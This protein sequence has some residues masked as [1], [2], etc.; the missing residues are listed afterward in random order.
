MALSLSPSNN[1]ILRLYQCF[2]QPGVVAEDNPGFLGVENLR[3]EQFGSDKAQE[4]IQFLHQH[5]SSA[6]QACR[7]TLGGQPVVNFAADS[8]LAWFEWPIIDELA[9]QGQMSAA[10]YGILAELRSLLEQYEVDHFWVGDTDPLTDC[11]AVLDKLAV[12]DSDEQPLALEISLDKATLV[13]DHLLG[14]LPALSGKISV[15]VWHS[16]ASLQRAFGDFQDFLRYVAQAADRPVVLFFY[17]PVEPYAGDFFKV[18]SLHAEP[19]SRADCAA[20]LAEHLQALT[21]K[22][23]AEYDGLRASHKDESRPNVGQRFDLPQALFLWQGGYLPGYYPKPPF[24]LEGPARSLLIYALMAWLAERTKHESGRTCFKLPSS[25]KVTLEF[26]LTD[27][28]QG[29]NSLFAA[30]AN[31]QDVVPLLAYD[32]HRSVSRKHLREMWA[33]ALEGLPADRFTAG[34][35]FDTLEAVHQKFTALERTSLAVGDRQ[36]DLELRIF[37]KKEA[38]GGQIEFEL[39]SQRLKLFHEP[40]GS[41]PVGEDDPKPWIGDLSHMARQYLTRILEPDEVVPGA[42]LPDVRALESWGSE[43]WAELIPKELKEYYVKFR[44]E[45]DLAILIVSS[46]PAFPWELVKPYAK[47]GELAPQQIEDP[48]WA[49]QFHL[50]RWLAASPPP[51]NEIGFERVCCVMA[52]S[53]L[54]AAARE[55]QFF[56]ESGV[57]P[58]QPQTKAALLQLLSENQYDVLHFSCHGK[59]DSNQPDES[60]V[61]LP[62]GSLLHP[63][64][65]RGAALEEMIGQSRPL[66]FLNVCHSG[67]AG[68]TLTG[69][70]GWANRF[71][72]MGCGAFIGCGWEVSDPLAAEFAIAFYTG[73]RG[74]RPLGQAVHSARQQIKD[75]EPAN[76]TWLA[77]YLYGNPYCRIKQPS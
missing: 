26:S 45:K 13:E 40:A 36:P 62:D 30:E 46:D 1:P 57:D 16:P 54:S 35:F 47:K 50:A 14:G 75:M 19:G 22:L 72:D 29:G 27:V 58:A 6:L 20:V 64:E 11:L 38:T 65:L 9:R 44:Q 61:R 2:A 37:F 8:V 67:Q 63:R 5:A 24:F 49:V 52:A 7:L 25:V 41:R 17:E 39:T 51:A 42:A 4:L 21:P 66:V 74:G 10:C 56:R 71:I 15:L 28:K 43:L 31:W 48:C 76:S 69:L 59:F 70:G 18:L 33:Q 53:E 55:V 77:Y 34:H 3:L 12:C 60:V 68:P 23:L 73:F 32:I